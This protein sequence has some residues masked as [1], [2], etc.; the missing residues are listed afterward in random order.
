MG[1][2]ICEFCTKAVGEG[3][4]DTEYALRSLVG[5]TIVPPPEELFLYTPQKLKIVAVRPSVKNGWLIEINTALWKAVNVGSGPP[6]Q[7]NI[8]SRGFYPN[9]LDPTSLWNTFIVDEEPT[10]LV[11]VSRR[12]VSA[13]NA[14]RGRVTCI[15]CQKPLVP[16]YGTLL[17]CP[18]C[19]K[20]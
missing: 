8:C 5:K 16:L 3:G 12:E 17:W 20:E 19:E 2:T 11:G 7:I 15:S 14:V 18:A 6:V 4:A 13:L 1:K 9:A 10:V